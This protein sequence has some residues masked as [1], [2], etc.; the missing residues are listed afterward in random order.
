MACAAHMGLGA[1]PLILKGKRTER[2]SKTGTKKRFWLELLVPQVLPLPV[3]VG[4]ADIGIK[5]SRWKRSARRLMPELIES[6]RES[7]K[8]RNLLLLSALNV[9]VQKSYSRH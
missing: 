5:L 8:D 3:I 2:V 7:I 9:A 6:S 4:V 1:I